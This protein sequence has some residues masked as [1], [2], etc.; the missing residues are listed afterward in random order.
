MQKYI[1]SFQLCDL[2]IVPMYSMYIYYVL[3][4]MYMY[5]DVI[6]EEEIKAFK[7]VPQDMIEII[8][9]IT[10]QSLSFYTVQTM[11]VFIFFYFPFSLSKK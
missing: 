8:K 1:K 2:F 10:F 5:T 7:K 3:C 9:K 4:T 11:T 6:R